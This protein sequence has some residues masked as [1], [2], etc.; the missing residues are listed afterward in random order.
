M[1]DIIT[2]KDVISYSITILLFEI[3]IVSVTKK[4]E[5]S[6]SVIC[7]TFLSKQKNMI[8][9]QRK[10][11]LE[12]LCLIAV[13]EQPV[14]IADNDK[15]WLYS[16]NFLESNYIP[17]QL[18]QYDIPRKYKFYLVLKCQRGSNYSTC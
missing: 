1:F 17:V 4:K 6:I 9:Y 15:N 16:K 7:E 13:L 3:T 11:A 10:I 5:I 8:N 14:Q 2:F 18:V 12:Q